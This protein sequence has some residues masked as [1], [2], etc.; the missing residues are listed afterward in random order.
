MS[1]T[2]K[3]I[4]VTY[5]NLSVFAV[6]WMVGSVA[7]QS[8]NV[9][10]GCHC[11]YFLRSLFLTPKT[12]PPAGNTLNMHFAPYFLVN[13]SNLM[14]HVSSTVNSA[15]YFTSAESAYFLL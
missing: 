8:A 10:Q 5:F 9:N 14:K 12:P 1:Y 3:K 4:S 2:L 15:N 6:V 13:H 7:D 11:C